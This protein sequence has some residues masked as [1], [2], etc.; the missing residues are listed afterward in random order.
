M[1]ELLIVFVLTLLGKFRCLTTGLRLPVG[2]S[3]NW[4]D[5]YTKYYP[6]QPICS[7][8]C[9]A[10]WQLGLVL[11]PFIAVNLINNMITA[12]LPYLTACS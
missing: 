7:G 5:S 8:E 4:E 9:H 11:Y 3:N 1:I 6:I 12:F 2:T 10:H